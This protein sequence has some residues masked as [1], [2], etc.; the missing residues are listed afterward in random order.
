MKLTGMKS[1]DAFPLKA[2]CTQQI[3]RC[4]SREPRR[5]GWGAFEPDFLHLVHQL[6]LIS[7]DQ[8]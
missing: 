8:C 7:A 4:V 5:R 2:S 6:L 1:T 3:Q